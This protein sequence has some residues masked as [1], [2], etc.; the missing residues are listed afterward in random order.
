MKLKTNKKTVQVKGSLFRSI[1]LSGV[2]I[3]LMSGC[4]SKNSIEPEEQ[5]ALLKQ[6][7]SYT[8]E[9]LESRY[10]HIPKAENLGKEV[11]TSRSDFLKEADLAFSE[12]K[13]YKTE[14]KRKENAYES[15]IASQ[16]NNYPVSSSSASSTQYDAHALKTV[17]STENMTKFY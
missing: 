6:E 14:L 15:R 12:I 8:V 3:L 16:G 2:G 10:D 7:R 13:D 17:N 4:S 9:E 5:E 1:L 11:S